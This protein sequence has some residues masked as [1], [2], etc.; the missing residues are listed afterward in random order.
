MFAAMY[1]KQPLKATKQK[2]KA[3]KSALLKIQITLTR[4]WSISTYGKWDVKIRL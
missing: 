3:K 1:N 2:E 4:L